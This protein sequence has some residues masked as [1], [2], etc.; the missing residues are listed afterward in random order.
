MNHSWPTP[1]PL[2]AILRG[3]RPE[4][5]LAQA[6]A[7][8]D[9]GF[10]CIEVPTNSPE[11]ER[12]VHMLVHHVGQRALV[13]AGT[14]WQ[15][16]QLQTLIEVGGRLMVTPHADAALVAR[17]RDAGLVTAIGC[18]TATE[19]FAAINAGA[20]A[21]KLF[22]AGALGAPYVAALRSVLPAEVPLFAVGG[23]RPD[24]LGD[25]VRVGCDGAGLGG[26]LYRA[27]QAPQLTREKAQRFVDAWRAL[28]R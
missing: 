24:N 3:V 23:V 13:G 19:A 11:W 8:L 22:P 9:A 14:V 7:L 25:F 27:G 10:D 12:S 16:A 6:G 17:A 1:L 15:P 5:V 21:L 26:E 28:P 2:I 4:E 20:Q 18:T